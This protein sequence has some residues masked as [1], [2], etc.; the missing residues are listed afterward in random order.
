[1]HYI[2]IKLVTKL[3]K[4]LKNKTMLN[5]SEMTIEEQNYFTA[6]LFIQAFNDNKHF[7]EESDE[8]VADYFIRDF[9]G[10]PENWN[11]AFEYSYDEVSSKAKEERKNIL[12]N[13]LVSEG[14]IPT[15][16]D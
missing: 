7:A 4:Q 13:M 3:T 16:E 14:Y 9:E 2:C 8:N 12:I 6:Q 5:L 10:S 11:F 1:M 15:Q